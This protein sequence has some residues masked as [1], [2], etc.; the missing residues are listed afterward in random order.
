MNSFQSQAAFIGFKANRRQLVET[1]TETSW[2]KIAKEQ[3]H[4]SSHV[5]E[6]NKSVRDVLLEEKGENNA[7]RVFTSSQG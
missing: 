1:E 6:R 3:S 5:Q 2:E 7:V 4:I